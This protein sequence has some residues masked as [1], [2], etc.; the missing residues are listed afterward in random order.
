[1]KRSCSVILLLAMLASACSKPGTAQKTETIMGTQVSITVAAASRDEA[2]SA[3]EAG[4]A[5]FR[6]F[7]AMM[8]LYKDTSEISRVNLAAG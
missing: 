1:M 2:E 7:D 5:E 4:M 6:R 3:I 8:S